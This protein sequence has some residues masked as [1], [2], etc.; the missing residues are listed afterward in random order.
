VWDLGREGGAVLAYTRC[1]GNVETHTHLESESSHFT[2]RLPFELWLNTSK[3]PCNISDI[4]SNLN[5]YGVQ[6][7][8]QKLNENH[9]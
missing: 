7:Q 1:Q 2:V 5:S 4:D 8:K 3:A 9:N 6:T